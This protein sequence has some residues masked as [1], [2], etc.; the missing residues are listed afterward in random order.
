V[1]VCGALTLMV[2]ERF[3]DLTTA[4]SACGHL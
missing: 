4:M 1:T 2:Y 3:G